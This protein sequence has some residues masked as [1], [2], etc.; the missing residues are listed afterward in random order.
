MIPIVC[1]D[2][3][4]GML[5]A[6]RRQSQDRVLRQ[7]ILKEAQGHAL[8]MNAYSVKQFSDNHCPNIFIAEDYLAQAG[9]QDFCFV[10]NQSLAPYLS[11]ISTLLVYRW[12]RLYPAD[13]YLDITLDTFILESVIEFDGYSHKK[14]QKERYRR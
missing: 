14:I 11:R 2:E 8:W 6:G 3:R 10:E 7:D 4:N 9:E 13:F 12:D 5:F 1:V